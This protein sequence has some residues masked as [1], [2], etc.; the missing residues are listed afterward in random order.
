MERQL[1][2]FQKEWTVVH[3]SSTI[4]VVNWWSL[5]LKTGAY[6]YIDD[7]L[8]DQTTQ[9]LAKPSSP[10]LRGKLSDDGGLVEVYVSAFHK[11]KVAITVNG[12]SIYRDHVGLVERKIMES[13]SRLSP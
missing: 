3:K 12:K 4:K 9:K 7:V 2:E 11:V 6:L 8:V 10:C 5:S 1:K 13:V